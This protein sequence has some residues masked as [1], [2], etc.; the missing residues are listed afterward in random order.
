MGKIAFETKHY[1][2]GFLNR[3][4][5]N[6]FVE[7]VVASA[8]P[9]TQ[10]ENGI[11]SMDYD[12]LSKLMGI[13]MNIIKFYGNVDLESIGID[14]LYTIASDIDVDEFVDEYD[15]NKVQFKDMLAAID[16]KCGYIKQQ[17]IASAIDIKLDS[18]DVN[19]KVEG[20]DDLVESVVALAP[21]LEYINEVF[22][23]ADPEVTQKMMQYFAEHGFD[24]TAEDITKP[25]LNLMIFRKIELM[26]LKQL[27][28]VLLMQLIIMW[29]LLTESKVISWETWVQ[30]LGYG[31]KFRMKCVMP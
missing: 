7:A 6:D 11:S 2:D 23:K 18:K 29:F 27:N 1:E 12:P 17:L 13:K 4:E 14:E 25:L 8:F 26:H 9:V 3:F 20:V 16:E 24:F 21:A 10:D 19:F 31:D 30:W 15:I 5:A 28:R 22:A